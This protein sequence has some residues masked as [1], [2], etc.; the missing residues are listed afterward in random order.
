VIAGLSNTYSS[1]ITT[2]EEYAVQRYEG[3]FTLYGQHTLDAYIQV[4]GW[5]GGQLARRGLAG[6]QAGGRAGWWVNAQ[7]GL[8]EP[9]GQDGW[10]NC[11]CSVHV[12]G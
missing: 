7:F 5:L 6:R 8:G 10:V 1:Y 11:R 2:P 3:G 12:A 9:Q 4:G